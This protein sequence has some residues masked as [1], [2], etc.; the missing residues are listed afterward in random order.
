[1]LDAAGN[2]EPATTAP[3]MPSAKMAGMMIA[4]LMRMTP[5]KA[6]FLM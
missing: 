1:V 5:S 4:R 6:A 2:A 3:V